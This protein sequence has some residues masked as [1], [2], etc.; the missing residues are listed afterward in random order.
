MK[1]KLTTSFKL[2]TGRDFNERIGEEGNILNLRDVSE[3]VRNFKDK[4]EN[5][6]YKNFLKVMDHNRTDTT[7]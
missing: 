2:L 3:I 5:K 4:T 1:R 6:E 7:R